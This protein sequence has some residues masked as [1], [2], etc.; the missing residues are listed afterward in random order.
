MVVRLGI[1][2]LPGTYHVTNAGAVSWYEFVREIFS[3]AG[4][5]PERVR[6][7]TSAELQP[8]RPA[9]RP[10]NSVLENFALR[11]SGIEPLR[12]FREPLREVVARLKS[13]D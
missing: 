9:P 7:I 11:H 13:S 6:P 10:A 5:D 2:R 8:P 3:A 4:H 1:S 12:D